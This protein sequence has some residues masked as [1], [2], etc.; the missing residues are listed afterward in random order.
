MCQM[1][2]PCTADLLDTYN[3]IYLICKTF[4]AS[5]EYGPATHRA[6]CADGFGSLEDGDVAGPG[7]EKCVSARQ[8]TDTTAD[9]HH[10]VFVRFAHRFFKLNMQ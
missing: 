7:F 1:A 9:D 4:G 3:L 5:L 8:T 10:V 2:V 6:R